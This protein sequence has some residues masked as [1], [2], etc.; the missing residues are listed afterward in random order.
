LQREHELAGCA[1]SGCRHP[2]NG[3]LSAGRRYGPLAFAGFAPRSARRA[4]FVYRLISEKKKDDEDT[5]GVGRMARRPRAGFLGLVSALSVC[6]GVGLGFAVA[7]LLPPRA[8]SVGRGIH[9]MTMIARPPGSVSPFLSREEVVEE[10]V[11]QRPLRWRAQIAGYPASDTPGS[12]LPIPNRRTF[13][14]DGRRLHLLVERTREAYVVAPALTTRV[15]RAERPL[16]PED[17]VLPPERPRPAAPSA[18]HRI[19]L[20]GENFASVVLDS[21]S[22]IPGA[23]FEVPQEYRPTGTIGTL[24]ELSRACAF[25]WPFTLLP[26]GAHLM[27]SLPELEQAAKENPGNADVHYFL[28]IGL[29]A[30]DDVVGAKREFEKAAKINP[31]SPYPHNS[32]A[33]MYE[34]RGAIGPAISELETALRLDPSDRLGWENLARLY[35]RSGNDAKATGALRRANSLRSRRDS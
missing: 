33:A 19:V 2:A 34:L 24:P 30:K 15:R 4:V 13:I 9:F 26:E 8:V 1:Q 23:L 17:F 25:T 11:A 21:D 28:G 16:I 6:V 20:S 27:P 3:G 32:L 18:G 5:T 7:R 12:P 10:W 14:F 31:G 22:P 29:E 35:K